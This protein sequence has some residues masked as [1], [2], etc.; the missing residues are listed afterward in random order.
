MV[1][2]A[3]ILTQY[4]LSL[5]GLSQLNKLFFVSV[6]YN[7]AQRVGMDRM[8]YCDVLGPDFHLLIILMQKVK[9]RSEHIIISHVIKHSTYRNYG[10]GLY[11][12][13]RTHTVTH[14]SKNKV[15]FSS[16]LLAPLL[17][18]HIT[19]ASPVCFVINI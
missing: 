5:A 6:P 1:S 13:K 7:V 11:L 15:G 16:L 19:T 8:R 14:F 2:L 9:I 17:V 12:L 3:V 18:Q 10:I 4:A